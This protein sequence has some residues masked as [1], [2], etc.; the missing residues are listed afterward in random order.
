MTRK[1]S[2]LSGFLVFLTAVCARADV[3]PRAGFQWGPL[4]SIAIQD[5]GRM[6]PFD[7]FAQESLQYVTSNR[8][9]KGMSPT[10]VVMGWLVAFESEWSKEP[11]IR[12]SYLPLK[13]TMGLDLT[14]SYFSP[15]EIQDNTAL[16]DLVR[17]AAQ[18]DERKERLSDLEKKAIELQ[19]ARGLI[20]AIVTGQALTV[21]PNP[22]GMDQTWIP[23]SALTDRSALATYPPEQLDKLAESLRQMLDAFNHRDAVTWNT[24][25]ASFAG[26]LRDDLGRGGYPSAA[27]LSRE[28][29]YNHLRPFRLAWIGYLTAFVLLLFFGVSKV[30]PF[31]YGGF[32]ALV[33]AVG[34]HA[35][36]FGLRCLIAGRPPVTNMY[37][38]IIWVTFG[39]VFFSLLIAAAYK[40]WV[41]PTAASA[42][43]I[44][45]LVL[46][47][48]LPTVLDPSINPLEPVLRSNYWLTIHVLTITLSYA[49]FALSLC[50]GNVV[51]GTYVWNPSNSKRLQQNSLYMYR[52]MQI[53]VILLA[54]GTILGGVWA[55]YSWGRFWGWDPK[56]VWALIALLLYLAVL[57]GRFTGWLKGFGFV[58]CTVVSFLGVLMAWYGVNF[59]LGV[60]LHSYGF[61]TGGIAYILSY[62]AAQLGFTVLAYVRYAKVKP[63]LRPIDTA[64]F[65][66]GGI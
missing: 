2:L 33:A 23:L 16:R 53:G 42:F 10:E 49:A 36:G 32:A 55:D 56:E 51:L 18:K 66:R 63:A 37:E 46:A 30:R 7:T 35:Y 59:V 25:S 15:A 65:P 3:A 62:V 9:W 6:K 19:N 20:Q 40:N 43:A 57:H 4:A 47:D 41:I 60:G 1:L 29:Q 45:G 8:S 39:C 13:Q 14:R 52:A 64:I 17:T 5:R 34:V 11:F 26:T 48:T 31:Q 54:A 27:S 21:L 28:I 24:A 38:S 61:G 22:Q 12:I 50:L 58:A 44:V